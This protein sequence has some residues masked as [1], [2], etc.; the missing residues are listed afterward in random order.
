[1][2]LSFVLLYLLFL[3]GMSL[4]TFCLYVAD[5]HKAK[6]GVWRI[7]ERVLLLCSLLG[8][9]VGGT[10]AM[11]T[12]RHKTKHWYFVAVNA[13]GLILQAALLVLIL[14]RRL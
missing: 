13:L 8:G 7:P 14:I 2:K 6:R 12:V 5:K 1:M 10:F 9:A 3:A 4:V 11:Y